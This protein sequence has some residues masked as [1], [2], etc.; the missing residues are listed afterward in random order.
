MI[1]PQHTAF[2]IIC[3]DILMLFILYVLGAVVTFPVLMAIGLW[4]PSRGFRWHR[5]VALVLI[6]AMPYTLW[7][8][9][10]NHYYPAV[11]DAEVIKAIHTD[12]PHFVLPGKRPQP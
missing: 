7:A 1:Q 5:I 9:Y 2:G 10:M 3:S 6:P 8:T 12:E 11:P 4:R